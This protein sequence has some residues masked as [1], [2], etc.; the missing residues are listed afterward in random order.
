[1]P[2]D[3]EV[4]EIVVCLGSSCFARGNSRI[5]P[6]SMAYLQSHGL[7]DFVR[8]TGRLCQDQCKQGPNLSIGGE[9]ASQR[10]SGKIARTAPAVRQS[11]SGRSWN[12]LMPSTPCGASARIATSA[13]ASVRS[14]RFACKMVM[15]ASCPEL[16]ILCGN[17]VLAC[18]S[19]AKQVRDDLPSVRHFEQAGAK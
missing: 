14:R 18:P 15:R 5:S 12:R 16:C 10:D 4:V 6:S 3:D 17:C 8:L 1:M 9:L 13:F 2:S 19:N 7:N 11:A